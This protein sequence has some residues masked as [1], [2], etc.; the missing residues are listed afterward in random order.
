MIAVVLGA[1]KMG[2]AISYALN[3]ISA[4]VIV[5]DRDADMIRETLSFCDGAITGELVD[6]N[7]SDILDAHKPDVV[8]SS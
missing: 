2:R 7:L 4:G 5:V 3:Q 8:I 6:D 1:G